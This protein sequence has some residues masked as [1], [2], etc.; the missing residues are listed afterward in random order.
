V[1]SAPIL[2]DPLATRSDFNCKAEACTAS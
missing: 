2:A 1:L